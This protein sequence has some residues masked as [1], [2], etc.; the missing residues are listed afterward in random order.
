MSASLRRHRP[1]S[2]LGREIAAEKDAAMAG[3]HKRPT[4][5]GGCRCLNY[6]Q[7]RKPLLDR[8]RRFVR[9]KRRN[10]GCEVSPKDLPPTSRTTLPTVLKAF[11]DHLRTRQTYKSYRKDVSRL[12]NVSGEVCTALTIRPRGRPNGRRGQPQPDKYARDHRRQRRR[13]RLAR[14]GLA[15]L[16]R[17]GVG[18]VGLPDTRGRR[19]CG[20][21]RRDT[22]GLLPLSHRHQ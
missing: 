10:I 11:C 8:D 6:R 13:C 17:L 20:W 12:R 4:V 5:S 21:D 14:A 1:G 16:G 22:P 3:T 2:V 7:A 19:R 15:R 18:M 9:N